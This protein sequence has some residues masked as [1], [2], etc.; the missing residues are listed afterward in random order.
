[1]KNRLYIIP[2]LFAFFSCKKNTTDKLEL[3]ILNDTLIAYDFDLKKDT[4]N[5]LQFEVQNNSDVIYYFNPLINTNSLFNQ[6]VSKNDVSLRIHSKKDNREVNYKELPFSFGSNKSLRDSAVRY[7]FEHITLDLER[8]KASDKFRYYANK[9]QNNHFF[10]HPKEKLFFEIYINLTDT[11]NSEYGRSRFAYLK[12]GNDYFAKMYLTSDSTTIKSELPRNI[13]K[14]IK[15]N[16]V[17]VY[18][19]ILESKNSIPVKVF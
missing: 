2:C 12:R 18:H 17:T 8:L 15:E 4:I 1:M 10:I 3:K 7:N 6:S 5:L 11:L 16:N 9:E 19:G 13:L 14:T